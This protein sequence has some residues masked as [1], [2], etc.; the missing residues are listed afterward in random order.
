MEHHPT[1]IVEE[2]LTAG[3]QPIRAFILAQ[4]L[5]HFM[6]GGIQEAIASSK[7]LS[8][9]ALAQNLNLHKKR[10]R[11]FLRYLANEGYVRLTDNDTVNLTATGQEIADFH[12]WYKLLIGGYAKTFQ[13]L[14]LVLKADGPYAERDSASVGVGS[15]GISQHDALPMTRQLLEKI[16]GQWRTVIDLGCGDGSYLVDLC[17]A[18]PNIRGIGLDSDPISVIVALEAASYHGVADRVYV[19]VGSATALPDFSQ[20][21]RPL[22]FI[23]AFVLQEVLEQSGRSAILEM[24]NSVFDHYPDS[25]WV[26]IEVDHRPN[27][28]TVMKKGLGLAYYNP[29][30]LIHNLTQQRL[31]KVEFWEKLYHEAGLHTVSI[32]YPDPSYD[33]L[34]LKVGFLLARDR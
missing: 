17:K 11:G 19:Q 27:D 4:A 20:E 15:C 10:L 18:N 22:C 28:P 23:T 34:G 32:V 5:Y 16:P 2:R 30:Y 26:V 24:L 29:Y 31:E 3:L 33:S 9:S 25:Y 13:Q 12:P 8:V 7:D 6:D 1:K 14:S 21:A